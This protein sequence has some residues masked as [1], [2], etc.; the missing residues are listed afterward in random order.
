MH[1][2]QY[3]YF[4][5]PSP[6]EEGDYIEFLAKIN[7]AGQ[8]LDA[9]P[10]RR[11]RRLRRPGRRAG[12]LPPDRGDIQTQGGVARGAGVVELGGERVRRR[13]RPEMQ[14]RSRRGCGCGS[15]T[16]SFWNVA[17]SLSPS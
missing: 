14:R 5:K 13:P 4:A 15:S 6:V 16:L 11:E 3:F 7:P 8:R 1:A 12:L 2:N 10:V 9:P 17:I